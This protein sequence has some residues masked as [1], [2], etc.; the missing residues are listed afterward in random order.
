MTT[1]ADAKA[2]LAAL[3]YT[4]GKGRITPELLRLTVV[5][6][7]DALQAEIAALQTAVAAMTN[8]APENMDTFLEALARFTSDEALIASKADA[9]A[10][11]AHTGNTNNPHGVTKAQ[12]GL[13][14]ADNTADTEK[15]VSTAQAA[16]DSAVAS[17]AAAALSS[18]ASTLGTSAGLDVPAVGNATSGQVVKGSDTRLTD[19]RAPTAHSHAASDISDS[20]AAG[21][22]LLT[23]ASVA[24]QKTALS[25][26]TAASLDVGTTASKV[27]QLDGSG[28]LPAVDGSQ[29]TGLSGSGEV[30]T[31]SNSASGTGTGT[32]FKTKSGVDLVFKKLLQGANVTITNGTDD[33]T[34]AAAAP[35]TDAS[36]LTSG[37]LPAA[38]LPA[39]TGDVTASVGSHA[40]TIANNAVATSKLADD[41]VTYAKLQN[42]SATSRVIGR[43]TT[44]AGDPE[45]LTLSD[46]L[47]FI[48]SA[49][50]G[51]IIYRGAS[52]W[53]RL[54]AGT[55][56]QALLTGGAG[57]NPSWGAASGQWVEILNTTISS[58]VANV[59]EI[60][61]AHV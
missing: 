50:Q 58:A 29:L 25:L 56:G 11:S 37:T 48:G 9:S 60:G 42:V 2:A 21:R 33:V 18:H 52:S 41:A 39:M 43:K 57:A 31:A 20:T 45:E 16:A 61:R 46:V 59:E 22:A 8:D 4:G 30:N 55:A 36:T 35:T 51:D 26:G 47:D 23:A 1:Y 6:V 49:A 44:G 12:I 5:D 17:A 14:N 38:R 13:G 34:I 27:V 19:S 28:K 10:L 15:P 53:A 54:S 24:A 40:T 7:S 3:L 32:I